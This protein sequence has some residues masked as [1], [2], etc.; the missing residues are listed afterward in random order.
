[1]FLPVLK[2]PNEDYHISLPA[3]KEK[4]SNSL[5]N[6]ETYGKRMYYHKRFDRSTYYYYSYIYQINMES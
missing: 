6:N 3:V 2:G 5:I 4:F 1:M